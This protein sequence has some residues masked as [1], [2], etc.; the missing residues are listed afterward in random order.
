MP[1]NPG[2]GVYTKPAP[3]VV[4]GTTVESKVYNDF[5]NDVTLDLNTAR[6][7]VAGGTGA[8]SATAARTNL[9][10]EVRGV[11][12]TNY[13]THVFE[14]GS[15]YSITGATSAPNGTDYFVGTAQ[16]FDAS[17]I[18]IQ[19]WSLQT[20][21]PA[22]FYVRRKNGGSWS[23]WIRQSDG[24]LTIS[25]SNPTIFLNKTG[26]GQIAQIQ[27]TTTNSARWAVVLGDAVAEAGADA[28]SNFGIWRFNDAAAFQDA[29]LTITR[30]T[31]RVTLA[32]TLQVNSA[33]AVG[34][35][36]GTAPGVG[37]TTLGVELTGGRLY[38]SCPTAYSAFNTNQDGIDVAFFRSGVFVGNISVTTTATAYNTSSDERLKEDLKSF[39]AGNIIDDTNVYDFAWKATGLRSYGV[40]AQQAKD[41]YPH[42]TFHDGKED[43][44]YIDYSKYVP[45][46]LQELKALRARVAELEGRLG[47]GAQPA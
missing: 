22:I 33:V 3:D 26:S 16:L 35:T 37:N 5:V 15:F 20:P 45:V 7:I 21:T 38:A 28:G 2:T 11:Q 36:P 18:Y 14:A 13:D 9:S 8:S 23:A 41:I 34:T 4:T 25:K 19:V 17:N 12:V 43:R 27:G 30:S 31:G 42:A 39:D 24:D 40:I 44:W 29:P 1:R 47:A 10:A 6:P 46:I 32:S